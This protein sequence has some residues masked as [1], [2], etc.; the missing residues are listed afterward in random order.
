MSDPSSPSLHPLVRGFNDAEVY[1]RGR[2]PYGERVARAIVE[3]LELPPG[4]PVLDLGAGAG[5][6]SRALLA[7]GLEVT[8]VEPLESMRIVLARTIGPGLVR[9][10]T[11]EEIP[12]ADGSV[13]A[14][15][16]ADSF[17]WFDEQRALPE[18]RR[19][20]R[21]SGGVGIMRTVPVLDTAWG[22]ELGAL[23][24]ESRPE[25]PAFADRGAAA[26][27]EEDPA[28]GPVRER[29]L[30]TEQATDRE[31]I[32]AYLASLSWVGSLPGQRREELLANAEAVLSRHGVGEVR[33]EMLHQIFFARLRTPT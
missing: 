16:A 12:L 4:A 30:T 11:A 6:L 1:D 25:H 10:G 21:R 31:R 18:I 26:A 22:R 8:A 24:T 29:A 17:H 5:A 9:R 32:L 19:V 33:H 15:L 3:E 7:C 14:V 27:L 2:P 23:I 28:F 20:L 13:D